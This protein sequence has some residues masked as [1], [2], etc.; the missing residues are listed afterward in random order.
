MPLSTKQM[1][2][3]ESLPKAFRALQSKQIQPWQHTNAQAQELRLATVP[4]KTIK[5]SQTL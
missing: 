3:R 1:V 4:K 5:K 2:Q